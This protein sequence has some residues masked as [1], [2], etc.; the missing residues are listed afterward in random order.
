M[1]TS[2]KPSIASKY[3]NPQWLF[4]FLGISSPK[5]RAEID[6]N[7]QK[8]ILHNGILRNHLTHSATQAQTEE[9]FGFKWKKRDTF[10]S[11]AS[12]DRM[13]SWLTE[14]YGDIPSASWLA[15][16]GD[17][18]ILIDAGCGA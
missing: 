3:E 6:L 13:R 2:S 16:H 9:T 15:E 12:Q 4:D 10:D 1:T 18:P 7:G 8:F 11:K 5:D 17:N 14:R